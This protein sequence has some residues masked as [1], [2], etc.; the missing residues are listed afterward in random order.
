MLALGSGP[1]K[2]E[3]KPWNSALEVM[4]LHFMLEWTP[5]GGHVRAPG[6]LSPLSAAYMRHIEGSRE[7]GVERE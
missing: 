7:T 3:S 6:R 5:E 1:V 2:A 4:A